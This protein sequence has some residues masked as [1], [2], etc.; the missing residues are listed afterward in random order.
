VQKP[1]QAH[2]SVKG[3]ENIF[4]WNP[5]CAR[6]LPSLIYCSWNMF[7]DPLHKLN[8]KYQSWYL[9]PYCGIEVQKP[10]QALQLVKGLGYTFDLSSKWERTMP[11]FSIFSLVIYRVPPNP[12]IKVAYR[13][14]SK[15]ISGEQR[16]ACHCVCVTGSDVTGSG[17]DWKWRQMKSRDR[18]WR[19]N[20]KYV[21]HLPGSAFPRFFSFQSS[22]TK[23]TIVHGRK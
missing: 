18:K 9:T 6:T 21:L 14:S 4:D 22:S 20:R 10:T 16:G 19:H 15:N 23:C 13:D 17:P 3:P 8:F 5:K 11:S 2:K 1:T 12:N 7:R